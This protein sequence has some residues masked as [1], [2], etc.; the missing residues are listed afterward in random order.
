MRRIILAL[1]CLLPLSVH[2]RYKRVISLA[3]SL[4]EIVYYIGAQ[5]QLI[6]NTRYCDYPA[7]AMNKEKIGGLQDINIEKILHLKPDLV[8][9]SWSGNSRQTAETLERLGIKVV[10][11]EEKQVSDIKANIVKM[12]LLLGR[13]TRLMEKALDKKIHS[14]KKHKTRPSCLVLLSIEPL[15][16]VSTHSFLGDAVRT[17]GYDNVITISTPYPQISQENLAR[18]NPQVIILT[19]D[20]RVQLPQLQKILKRMGLSPRILWVDAAALSR[21]GPR[22]YDAI[23]E[24]NAQVE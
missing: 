11:F 10:L 14:L 20:M 24:L 3:P 18:Y 16:S 4:T 7:E 8:L 23:R 17:A 19:E 13:D 15:F 2:A 6:A 1:L 21:P 9:A 22:L 5:G 12:G